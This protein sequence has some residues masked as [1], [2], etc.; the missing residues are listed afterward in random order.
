M[1]VACRSASPFGPRHAERPATAVFSNV[2]DIPA[3]KLLP[4]MSW[5]TECVGVSCAHCHVEGRWSSDER[6]AK[7]RARQ[8]LVMTSD[9]ARLFYKCSRSG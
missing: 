9:V 5:F 4:I 1:L 6:P 7:R 3:S 8:M 2:E